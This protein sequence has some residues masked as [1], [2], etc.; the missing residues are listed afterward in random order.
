MVIL[1]VL[2]AAALLTSLSAVVYI[3][4]PAAGAKRLRRFTDRWGVQICAGTIALGSV[5]LA[6]HIQW[7]VFR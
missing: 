6:V 5:L 2:I 1:I 3:P 7:G 4:Q